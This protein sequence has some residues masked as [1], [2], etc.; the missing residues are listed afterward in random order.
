MEISL[1]YQ[2][3]LILLFLFVFMPKFDFLFFIYSFFITELTF[4]LIKINSFYIDFMYKPSIEV[5]RY[6]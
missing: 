2:I 5:T 6:F 1:V 4:P 3:F